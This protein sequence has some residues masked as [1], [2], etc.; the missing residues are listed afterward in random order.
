MELL[1][2]TENF[3]YNFIKMNCAFI[4]VPK[5]I[6]SYL[7]QSIDRSLFMIF[8]KSLMSK[9]NYSMN[10][11]QQHLPT[12]CRTDINYMQLIGFIILYCMTHVTHKICKVTNLPHHS[13][14]VKALPIF[15]TSIPMEIIIFSQ[16]NTVRSVIFHIL[17][18]KRFGYME[19]LL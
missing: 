11:R 15:T 1:K 2:E 10:W 17:G 13:L 7:F 16:I 5:I 18:V 19:N 8:L 14:T 4:L 12:V 9:Q 6:F 3:I